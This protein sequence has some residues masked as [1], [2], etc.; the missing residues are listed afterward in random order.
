VG[1]GLVAVSWA[2]TGGTP[3]GA[4]VGEDRVGSELATGAPGYV[5]GGGV[6]AGGGEAPEVD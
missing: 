3:G 6:V 5:G 1:D 4:K 2:P